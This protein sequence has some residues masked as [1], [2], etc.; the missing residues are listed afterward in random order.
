MRL[1]Y[2]IPILIILAEPCFGQSIGGG[3]NNPGGGSGSSTQ[4]TASISS[5]Q[6]AKALL[7]PNWQ[8]GVGNVLAEIGNTNILWVGDSLTYALDSFNGQSGDQK[9]YS[10]PS[11]FAKLLAQATGANVSTDSFFGYNIYYAQGYDPRISL[12]GATDTGLVTLGGDLFNISSVGSPLTFTPKAAFNQ[13][14][15]YYWGTGGN[16]V[17][18]AQ[19]ASGTVNTVSTDVGNIVVHQQINTGTTATTQALKINY[20]SG[21]AVNPIGAICYNNAVPTIN[22]INTGM[23]GRTGAT[24][25]TDVSPNFY[26]PGDF[27]NR[28]INSFLA[29]SMTVYEFGINDMQAGTSAA[30]FTTSMN[31]VVSGYQGINSDVLLIA[32]NQIG[33]SNPN[34]S[35]TNQ[36]AFQQ[37]IQAQSVSSKCLFAD[38]FTQMGSFIQILARNQGSLLDFIHLNGSGYY[39]YA[40]AIKGLL[41]L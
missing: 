4:N 40:A 11:Q 3:I 35:F 9:T 30:T 20:S 7:M 25:A 33:L 26:N 24:Q 29:P 14:D 19:I 15:I 27:S 18:S 28:G 39:N 37:A 22:V 5:A 23:P 21:G 17:A 16:G 8:A 34:S 10:P 32:P 36:Q 31:S 1:K 12:G 41:T 2:L 6:D 13:C 38:I